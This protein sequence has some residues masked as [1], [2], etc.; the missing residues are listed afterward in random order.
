VGAVAGEFHPVGDLAEGRLDPVAPLGDDFQQDGGH[1]GALALI[2]RDED[3]GAAGGQLRFEGPAAE[4]LVR[5][6]VGRGPASSRSIATSRSLTAAGTMAQ[7]RTIRLP[8]SVLTA[9][10]KP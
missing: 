10:R 2:A 1:G 5:E 6:Q 4:A 3:G 7:A 9:R 8:R